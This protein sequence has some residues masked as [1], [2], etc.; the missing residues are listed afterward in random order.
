VHTSPE[1][2]VL[3]SEMA[4]KRKQFFDDRKHTCK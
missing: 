1:G 4:K 2:G 3:K